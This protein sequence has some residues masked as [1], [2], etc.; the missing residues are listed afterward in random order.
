M[1]D[2]GLLSR[3]SKVRILLDVN[4]GSPQ[5][6]ASVVYEAPGGLEREGTAGAAHSL[7]HHG[8]WISE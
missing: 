1:I 5:T 8:W 3:R 6:G 4:D 2:Y 7:I